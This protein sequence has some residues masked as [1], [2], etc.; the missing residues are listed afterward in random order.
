MAD[1]QCHCHRS[2]RS[3]ALMIWRLIARWCV[4]DKSLRIYNDEHNLAMYARW[5]R[6]KG[7]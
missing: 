2:D 4:P 1:A 7:R 6:E 3:A 5:L